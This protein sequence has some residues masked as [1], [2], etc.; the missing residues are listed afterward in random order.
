MP[1]IFG[2]RC[3]PPRRGPYRALG[4][5][6]QPATRLTPSAQT[7]LPFIASGALLTAFGAQKTVELV[8][9][10]CVEPEE[11]QSTS[12]ASQRTLLRPL[13]ATSSHNLSTATLAKVFGHVSTADAE[14]R[15]GA[16][17]FAAHAAEA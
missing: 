11:E 7:A 13:W 16:A 10:R 8:E 3:A 4:A 12:A 6:G 2:A 14:V 5:R 1:L 15:K 9:Q 17:L